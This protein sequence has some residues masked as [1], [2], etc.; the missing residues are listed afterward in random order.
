MCIANSLGKY[1]RGRETHRKR[2]WKERERKS[3]GWKTGWQQTERRKD[4]VLSDLWELR[5]SIYGC[6]SLGVLR[7]A[8]IFHSGITGQ[9]SRSS[10]GD[11]ERLE[12]LVTE[13]HDRC[14]K[15]TKF[16]SA[17]VY[18]WC[19]LIQTRAFSK[20]A[21]CISLMTVYPAQPSVQREP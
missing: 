18:T 5:R 7:E 21:H 10:S 12:S 20:S 8:H 4:R 16:P 14:H 1:K 17:S 2:G 13:M 15:K 19:L 3:R 9:P 11:L 6:L